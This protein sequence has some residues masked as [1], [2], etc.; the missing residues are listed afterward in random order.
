MRKYVSLG[1]INQLVRAFVAIGQG[2][3]SE[4]TEEK[5]N[6]CMDKWNWWMFLSLSPSLSHSQIHKMEKRKIKYVA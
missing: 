5:T 4:Y 3:G 1:W 6:G 2:S